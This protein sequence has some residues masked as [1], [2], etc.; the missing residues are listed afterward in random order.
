M[1]RAAGPEPRPS[2]HHGL[3]VNA[4]DFV[5]CKRRSTCKPS[6]VSNLVSPSSF[7]N[8]SVGVSGNQFTTPYPARKDQMQKKDHLNSNERCAQIHK[9]RHWP[10]ST[11]KPCPP[12]SHFV[13]VEMNLV[14]LRLGR[15]RNLQKMGLHQPATRRRSLWAKTVAGRA[16]LGDF[17]L[18]LKTATVRLSSFAKPDQPPSMSDP[19][20]TPCLRYYRLARSLRL[21]SDYN[22]FALQPLATRDL[23][24]QEALT[25]NLKD[26]FLPQSNKH[27]S[28][29]HTVNST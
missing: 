16:R 12:I 6:I 5:C 20:D 14:V 15:L 19:H 7:L 28:A 18:G 29:W 22:T 11:R 17:V 27:P 23:G 9:D 3:K 13:P 24:S 10:D 4:A 26:V 1:G 25:E 8:K 21:A 2:C